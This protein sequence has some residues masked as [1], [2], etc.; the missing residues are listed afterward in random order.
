M[1]TNKLG[2]NKK[3]F[4]K[5]LKSMGHQYQSTINIST[6]IIMSLFL[7][8]F[9]FIDNQSHSVSDAFW[10]VEIPLTL[11]NF[12]AVYLQL[13]P[14]SCVYIQHTHDY[15]RYTHT[16]TNYTY[17]SFSIVTTT[18]KTA[19]CR[20]SIRKNWSRRQNWPS[21]QNGKLIIYINKCVN[22]FII[23]NL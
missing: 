9:F 23:C 13:Q 1:H 2:A 18:T 15:N 19:T 16:Y 4:N 20:Q 21:N 12:S 14:W 7:Y 8:A 10:A 6:L 17:I 3:M 22:R 11:I 5:L